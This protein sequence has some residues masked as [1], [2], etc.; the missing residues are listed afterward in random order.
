MGSEE[1]G[2]TNDIL[3]MADIKAKIPMS[4]KI[5]SL[6]VGVATGMILYEKI[7]QELY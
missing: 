3:N 5:S 6:N 2:I 1:D 4:G 7:R